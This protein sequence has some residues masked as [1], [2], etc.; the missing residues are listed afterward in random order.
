PGRHRRPPGHR[1]AAAPAAGRA[2]PCPGRTRAEWPGRAW[3]PGG[4]GGSAWRRM[5]HLPGMPALPRCFDS[6]TL[7]ELRGGRHREPV[8]DHRHERDLQGNPRAEQDAVDERPP[9]VVHHVH[10]VVEPLLLEL[11]EPPSL[12]GLSRDGVIAERVDEGDDLLA[13]R[14]GDD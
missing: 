12:W 3:T 9:T 2:C 8:D 11:R 10:L 6:R 7:P 4:A 5:I 13:E 14:N 1:P